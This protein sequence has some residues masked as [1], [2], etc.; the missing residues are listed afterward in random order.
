LGLALGVLIWLVI[1]LATSL[2]P[3]A[4]Q[5]LRA[6]S[7][8]VWRRDAAIALLVTLAVG[9]GLDKL[10]GLLGDRFHAVLSPSFPG[11][12]QSFDA[13][14]PALGVL[15]HAIIYGV[16]GAAVLAIVIY[17]VRVGWERRAWWFWAGGILFLFAL[18]P[19]SAHSI[20]EY[21]AGWLIRFIPFLTAA[22]ILIVFFR[23][24]PLAYITAAF[25][26]V[27]APSLVDLFSQP[28]GF[29]RWNGVLL[30]IL[31]AAVL[32]WLLVPLRKL[33]ASS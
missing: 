5:T 13:H 27:V 31:V 14:S 12:G 17:G 21:G 25:G 26:S 32:L 30:S 22:V 16:V 20:A 3:V 19:N 1:A 8:A 9:S 18:G 7:R 6:S 2:F 33:Y 29:Y 28:I 10:L 15:F 4:W 23:N 24:N 11:V